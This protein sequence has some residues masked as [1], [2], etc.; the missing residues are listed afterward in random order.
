MIEGLPG[1]MFGDASAGIAIVDQLE[2]CVQQ[3]PTP[4]QLGDGEP[5][6]AIRFGLH[7]RPQPDGNVHVKQCDGAGHLG[8]GT[9]DNPK[10]GPRWGAI[11]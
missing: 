3:Q 6:K 2:Y 9:V 5:G 7:H 1:G 10:R 8:G 11:G 4:H